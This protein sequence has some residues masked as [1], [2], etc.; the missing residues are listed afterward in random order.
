M[1]LKVRWRDR[2]IHFTRGILGCCVGLS[3]G[4]GFIHL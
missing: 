3:D 2:F 1:G 4:D